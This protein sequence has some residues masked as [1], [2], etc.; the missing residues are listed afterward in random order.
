MDE[1]DKE[2]QE[3]RRKVEELMMELS[4]YARDNAILLR[5][6]KEISES[7]TEALKETKRG[8]AVPQ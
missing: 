1:K 7:M 5:C 6:L 8:C 4:G 3:L 2:L